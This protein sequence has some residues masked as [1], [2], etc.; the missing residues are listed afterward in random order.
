VPAVIGILPFQLAGPL[1]SLTNGKLYHTG[2]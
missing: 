2:A 1:I